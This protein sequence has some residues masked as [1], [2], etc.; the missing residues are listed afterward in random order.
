MSDLYK[1]INPNKLP[2]VWFPFYVV[3]K[4]QWCSST[5]IVG[6]ESDVKAAEFQEEILKK[7][8]VTR[9]E[10]FGHYP[11]ELLETKDEKNEKH[12]NG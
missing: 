11:R 12:N 5:F 10:L 7:N 3:Y 9:C 1:G 8:A 2:K 6:F 4:Y